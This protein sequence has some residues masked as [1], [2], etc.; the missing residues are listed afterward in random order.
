MAKFVGSMFKGSTLDIPKV[1]PVESAFYKPGIFPG[2]QG[3][4]FVPSLIVSGIIGSRD[5]KYVT[6]IFIDEDSY[7]REK[8]LNVFVKQID[9]G[10]KFT[11]VN[12]NEDKINIDNI[13]DSDIKK[14]GAIIETKEALKTKKYINYEYLG[15]SFHTII[16][17]KTPL[18]LRNA[19]DILNGFEL[20]INKVYL[21]N[22]GTLGKTIFHNDIHV[23]NIMFNHSTGQVYLIDFGF[24]TLDN[25]GKNK[26]MLYDLTSL[27]RVIDQIL[28]YIII[29]V[30]N[31]SSKRST[32]IQNFKTF[33]ASNYISTKSSV[34][35]NFSISYNAIDLVNQV[36]SLNRGFSE[37][38]GRR[39]T[40]RRNMYRK[41]LRRRKMG[42]KMH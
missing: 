27:V 33:V 25:P 36:A 16:G 39:K 23:G 24:A 38:G 31:P 26:N 7:K 42:R 30:P 28:D 34:P 40:H 35:K 8:A 19:Q 3:C 5:K 12:Y 18:T 37:L 14:C 20:L 21:M 29:T 6:K 22:K 41:T 32:A 1:T 17:Y 13:S 11:N 10:S 4:V 2:A 9:P 15:Q